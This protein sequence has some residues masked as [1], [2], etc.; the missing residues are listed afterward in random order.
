LKPIVLD[1]S[2]AGM[3]PVLPLFALAAF[4]T[5]GGASAQLVGTYRIRAGL[6]AQTLPKFPGSKSNEVDP[7]W[8]FSVARGDHPFT[9]G[10]PGDSAGVSLFGSG[11]FSAGPVARLSRKR[12]TSDVDAPVGHVPS[13][14]EL[15]GFVQYYPVKSLRLRAELRKGI[16]GHKGIVGFLGA[17]Q[18][19]RDGDSYVFSIGPRLWFG[20]S[21]YER[22]YFGVT[23]AAALATGLPEYRPGGSFHAAG[24]AAGL[25]YSIGKDWGVFGYAQYQRLIGDARRSPI[26]TRFGSSNQFSAGIGISHTFTIKL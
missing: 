7:Y 19:W 24:A 1:R 14:V 12:E 8:T 16:G 22:A 18:I 25:Q 6:G 11:G 17:D 20:D 5:S 2:L 23:P 10:A 21:R 15:G 3:K 9:F 13:T 4:C 26:I